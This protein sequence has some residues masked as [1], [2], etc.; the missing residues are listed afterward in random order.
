MERENLTMGACGDQTI[1]NRYPRSTCHCLPR[2]CFD[3][4]SCFDRG[5]KGLLQSPYLMALGIA[6]FLTQQANQDVSEL[7]VA[8]SSDL[9]FPPQKEAEK[10]IATTPSSARARS[11]IF[12]ISEPAVAI[13]RISKCEDSAGISWRDPSPDVGGG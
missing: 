10:V 3:G 7:F 12:S 1:S 11:D 9:N 5:L 2:N 6:S 4:V 13:Q 8:Q